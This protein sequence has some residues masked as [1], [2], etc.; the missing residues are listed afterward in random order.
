MKSIFGM[1]LLLVVF[2][3]LSSPVFA[4]PMDDLLREY[5]EEFEAAKPP[6]QSSV[7]ADYKFD[8]IAMGGLFTARSLR[9]LYQQTQ[10]SLRRQDEILLKYDQIIQ[11]NN[12]IIRLLQEISEKTP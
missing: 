9:L 8:Q 4:D 3:M 11:Q 2:P 1:V 6:P 12:E 10:E 5:Q 7:H